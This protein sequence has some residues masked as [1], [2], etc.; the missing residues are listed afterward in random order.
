M[1]RPSQQEWAARRS[2][3]VGER[4][5][6]E[7]KGKGCEILIDRFCFVELPGCYYPPVY[8]VGAVCS[9]R[10]EIERWQGMKNGYKPDSPIYTRI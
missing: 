10:V 7:A 4:K 2:V 8:C 5:A 1:L 6:G 9:R 3:A